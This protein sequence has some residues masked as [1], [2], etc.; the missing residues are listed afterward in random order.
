MNM[1]E[2][3]VTAIAL[4]RVSGEP[5]VVLNDQSHLKALPIW[6]GAAEARAISFAVK[7]VRTQRPLTHDLLFQTIK[8]LGHSIKEVLIDGTIENVFRATIVLSSDR[9]GSAVELDARPSDA[10]AL[11]LIA[12]ARVLVSDDLVIDANKIIDP[13]LEDEKAEANARDEFRKFVQNLKA[14]DFTFGAPVE[15][16]EDESGPA[17]E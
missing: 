8:Q 6:I 9:D 13:E 5:I 15:L 10:I 3:S 14:S 2:M 16:P 17:D 4:D 7:K 12:G 1:I 11:S